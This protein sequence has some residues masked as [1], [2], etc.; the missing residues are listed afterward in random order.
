MANT[1]G[2]KFGGRQKGTPNRATQIIRAEFEQFITYAS[3]KIIELWESLLKD[4]PREALNVI[5]DYAEFVLPKLARVENQDLD[6]NGDPT[7]QAALLEKDI[8]ILKDAGLLDIL[9]KNNKESEN[10]K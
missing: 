5:K 4:N 10:D 1:T 9:Q 7:D 3:P 2:Q 6:K 8:K